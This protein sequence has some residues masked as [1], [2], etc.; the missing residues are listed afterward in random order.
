VSLKTQSFFGLRISLFT[1]K[2]LHL[3]KK[4]TWDTNQDRLPSEHPTL[5][6]NGD[7]RFRTD[8]APAREEGGLAQI[9]EVD[10]LA[11]FLPETVAG[12]PASETVREL[13]ARVQALERSVI[14]LRNQKTQM[15]DSD[16]RRQLETHLI[17]LARSTRR[18]KFILA[19]LPKESPSYLKTGEIW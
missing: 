17:N 13:T 9:A 12:G 8:P 11:A 19:D 14:L 1:I 2:K 18:L 7:G 10:T 3:R 6:D 15:S 4:K 5:D 16:Y